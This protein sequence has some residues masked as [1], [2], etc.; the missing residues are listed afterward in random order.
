MTSDLQKWF[1]AV[2]QLTAALWPNAFRNL[3]LDAARASLTQ[4]APAERASKYA[5][6]H[7]E[8]LNRE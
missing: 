4:L 2:T 7:L 8:D 5:K 6:Q 3:D 1:D